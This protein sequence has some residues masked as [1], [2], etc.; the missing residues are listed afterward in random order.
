M[1]R[2]NFFYHSAG[3]AMVMNTPGDKMDVKELQRRLNRI[4]SS[5]NYRLSNLDRIAVNI[6]FSFIKEIEQE[7]PDLYYKTFNRLIHTEGKNE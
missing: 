4:S 1:P 7:F 3:E 5:K 2:K 6:S